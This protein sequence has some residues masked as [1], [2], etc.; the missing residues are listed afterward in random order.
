MYINILGRQPEIGIA[1]L[2]SLYGAEALTPLPPY[3][4][5]INSE[6]IDFDR[7]GGSQ[8]LAKVLTTLPTNDWHSITRYISGALPG[9]IQN[10]PEG[11]VKFGLSVYGVNISPSKINASALQLK[12]VIKSSKR[13]VRVVPNKETHLSTAQVLHNG[14]TSSVGIELLII[15]SGKR[16]IIARTTHVQDINAYA[17]RD[18]NR[19][20]RDTKVGMLPPKLAQII[21]NLANPEPNS[22]VLD[23]FCGT[24]VMLQESL[25]MGFSAAG[26]DLDERMVEYSAKNIQWL[27]QKVNFTGTLSII[28]QA[29]A[30]NHIWQSTPDRAASETYLGRPLSSEPD[31]Q[32][33]SKIM[34]DCDTIHTKFLKNIAKQTSLGFRMCLAVP[35]WKTRQ[36]FKHLKTLDSLEKLGYNRL[37]FVHAEDKDLIYHRKGQFVGRELVILERK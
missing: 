30:T 24:G 35:A 31:S 4:C 21:I 12:K 26:S 5:L 29:D 11:K 34:N 1:E 6:Q 28:E 25:L 23:P 32:T 27:N 10:M 36:G 16:T 20:M 19:P 2:E 22:I 13:G 33:L 7:L 18:Q 9:Y 37:K 14:L 3:A 17:H 8:K 15:K